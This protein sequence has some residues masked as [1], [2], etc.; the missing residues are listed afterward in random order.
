[1]HR[2]KTMT[3]KR[4]QHGCKKLRCSKKAHGGNGQVVVLTDVSKAGLISSR[5]KTIDKDYEKEHNPKIV[6]FS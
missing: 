6:K 1:M 5:L 2:I 3:H 4:C